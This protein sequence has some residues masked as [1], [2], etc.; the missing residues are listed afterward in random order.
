MNLKRIEQRQLLSQ[1][2]LQKMLKRVGADR[3]FEYF[4]FE[5]QPWGKILDP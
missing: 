2:S 1:L 4:S 3:I 5:H